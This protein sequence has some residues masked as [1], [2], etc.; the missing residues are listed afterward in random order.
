[1]QLAS[2]CNISTGYT[3]RGRLEPTQSGGVLVIQLRDMSANGDI[4]ADQLTRVAI[5]GALDRYLVRAGDVVFRSRGDRNTASVL[6]DSF[7]EPVLAVLPLMILRPK[8]NVLTPQYLAWAI[9]QAPAQRF[10]DSI[11]CGTNMR[12]LPKA[13]LEALEIE[14]PAIQTQQQIL[15]IHALAEQEQRLA[16]LSAEKRK[17]LTTLILNSQAKDLSMAVATGRKKK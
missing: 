9:N 8:A 4:A 5:D 1:M 2:V 13:G 7:I 15:E 3:A 10:F 12:M 11:A 6:D 17:T 14:V 16:I